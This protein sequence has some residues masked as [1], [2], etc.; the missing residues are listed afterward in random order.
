MPRHSGTLSGRISDR[1]RRLDRR[2]HI[3]HGRSSEW[4]WLIPLAGFALTAAILVVAGVMTGV[5]AAEYIPTALIEGLVIAGLFVA[6]LAPEAAPPDDPGDRGPDVEPV[7]PPP[8]F[9]P[10]L[11][12]ALLADSDGEPVRTGNNAK[13]ESAREPVGAAR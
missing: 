9:D 5:W 7:P 4:F 10:T 12:A 3:N 8:Q 11:W 6:C 13:E 2:L 1:L